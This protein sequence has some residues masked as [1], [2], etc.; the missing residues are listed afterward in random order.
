MDQQQTDEFVMYGIL[1]EH[2]AR[3]KVKL[4]DFRALV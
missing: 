3:G 4:E 2:A 1:P